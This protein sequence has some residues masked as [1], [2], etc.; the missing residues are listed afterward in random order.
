MESA[1]RYDVG[2]LRKPERTPQGF[3]RVDA[4]LT[5]SG[6]FVYRNAD[7][8]TRREYR[9][10]D[11]VFRED[12]LAS[13]EDAPV[14]LGHPARLLDAETAKTHTRGWLKE[15]PRRDG[16]WAAGRLVITDQEAIAKAER[17]NADGSPACGIS[18]GYR[19]DYDPTP[20]VTPNGDRYDGVQRNIRGNHVALVDHG[21]A[22]P[23]AT[24]RLDSADAVMVAAESTGG[25]EPPHKESPR[26]ATKTI[27]VD[28]V[29]YDTTEQLAQV[30]SAQQAK[31]AARID[32]LDAEVKRLKADIDK[33]TAR[34]DQAEADA[35]KSK[36]EREDG[37]KPE[38][39]QKL[40][41]ARAQLQAKATEV[42]G[43]EAKFDDMADL[44]IKRAVIEK[45]HPEAKSRMDS[46]GEGYIV[47][48]YDEAIEA[49]DKRPNPKLGEAR[50]DAG[51]GSDR[52]DADER[53]R[54]AREEQANAWKKD[55]TV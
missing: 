41:N 4:A 21:R 45:L 49:W 22:G 16:D 11:E 51:S 9:P 43:S 42:L 55:L 3:L 40:V 7:G 13:F 32:E 8:S 53:I 6:I 19:I 25:R 20:G 15:V 50:R 38:A 29:D 2:E 34:A 46:A 10:A 28:G 52:T 33:V 26:M 1:V 30:I 18:L 27:R 48:R 35:K 5:R 44:Q 12:S 23:G 36:Q 54:K 14:T 37:L 24:V 39:L 17:K 31:S 47:A